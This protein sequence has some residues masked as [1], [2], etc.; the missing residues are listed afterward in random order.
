MTPIRVA[1][2]GVE[3]VTLAEMRAVL[4]LGS[5]ETA[6]DALVLA[7]I[8]SA[9]AAVEAS[10]RRLLRP[11]R[12]RV[13]LLGWP[14][15]GLVPLP[16]SPLVAVERVGLIESN[17]AVT[18]IAA[19]VALG[20]DPWDAPWL[21]IGRDRPA[22]E[23]RTILV[24]VI[25][26]CG[27]DGPPVPEPLAQA[28]RLTVADGFENRGDTPEAGPPRALPSTAAGLCAACRRMLL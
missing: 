13:L 20:P 16:L 28:V 2:L 1:D 12:F 14:A 8:A 24:E 15:D 19:P 23:G 9:R 7:L 18:P 25:A 4:R 26:G 27:G 22:L 17:G 21:T 11:A 10:S 6:E 3:P 5:D